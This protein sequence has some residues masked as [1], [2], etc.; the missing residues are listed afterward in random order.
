M[1]VEDFNAPENRRAIVRTKIGFR[2]VANRLFKVLAPGTL[3]I[4]KRGAAILKNRVRTT[5]V[6]IALDPNLMALQ[7]LPR[8][9]PEFLRYQLEWRNLSRYVEDS[10]VP[11]LNNKDL[12]PRY[13]LRAPDE[14]QQEIIETV[15]AAEA[16]EGALIAK[17]DA[18]EDL[19]KSL[20]HDLLT[21]R[22]RVNNATEAAAS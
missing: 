13:F 20:M 10:G 8:M 7:V 4:A 12:Y 21:G 6:P 16:L 19:K 14:R 5:A 18:F 15:S 3:V 1:K 9:R 22:V 2:A 17:C 11:Q